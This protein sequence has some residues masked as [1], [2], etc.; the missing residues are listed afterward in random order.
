MHLIFMQITKWQLVNLL[1]TRSVGV[2]DSGRLLGVFSCLS[3]ANSMRS[4]HGSFSSFAISSLGVSSFELSYW[5]TPSSTLEERN[6][7]GRTD[8]LLNLLFTLVP[9]GYNR[10]RR[11]SYASRIERAQ[12]SMEAD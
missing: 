11:G 1:T 4:V 12:S 8:L 9:V 2:Q 5:K 3:A 7:I 6:C 10:I